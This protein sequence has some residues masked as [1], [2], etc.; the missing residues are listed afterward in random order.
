M[1]IA[2]SQPVF[3]HDAAPAPYV[4]A[5]LNIL[6]DFSEERDRLGDTQKAFQNILED[7]EA[8]K[9]QLER[10]K[11]AIR[12]SLREK[13]LLLGEI[14]HRVK[15]NLQIVQSLLDMQAGLTEDAGAARA[16]RDSQH[17]IQSMALIHQTLYQS[18]DFAEVEFEHFLHRLTHHLQSS[19][20]RGDL[21]IESDADH[22]CMPIDRAIP[23]GLIVNELVTN[24]LK[25]A[26]PD[27]RSGWVRVQLK[28]PEPGKLILS[29]ADNGIGIPESL[30][31]DALTSLGVQLIHILSEQLH[32]DLE[33]QRRN[34]TRFTL[35]FSSDEQGTV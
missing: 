15:N 14:H 21:L 18:Q 5:L 8:E 10:T 9:L 24:A 26:F 27:H 11:Q 23:C 12:E 31:F 2:R 33:I 35:R 22:V 3:P 34:P 30:D 32:A 4:R 28:T 6:E 19:Y 17:R 7:L 25:H 1:S 29:I 13:E 20:G 16:L